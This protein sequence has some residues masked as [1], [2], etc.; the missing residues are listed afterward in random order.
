MRLLLITGGRHKF[1]ETTPI[2]SRFLRAAGHRVKV[3]R[4]APELA[5]PAL[6]RYDAIV[7]NTCRGAKDKGPYKMP[8]SELNNDFDERQKQGLHD[9]VAAGGGL[10]SLHVAPTS[11]P[12]WPEMMKMTGGGWVWGKSWHPPY[13]RFAVT[14]TDPTHPVVRG[15]DRFEIDDEIYCD[16]GIADGARI[17]LSASH[18][19]RDRPLAWSHRYGAARVVNLSFGHDARSVSNPVFQQLM[20]NAVAW[21]ARGSARDG[22]WSNLADSPREPGRR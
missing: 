18:A 12:G 21:I 9:F 2:I 15:I 20:L 8:S 6:A 7:L 10:L 14:L 19:G 3:T 22:S 13:C 1:Y 4:A 17:F 11:C 5:R 16:L